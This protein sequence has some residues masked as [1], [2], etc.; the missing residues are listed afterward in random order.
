MIPWWRAEPG[1]VSVRV[2]VQP[3]ARRAGLQGL[4]PG[5]D[6]PRLKL[7]VTEA[8]EDG[9]AN[10][11]VCA[12][13]ARALDMPPSAAEV[14]ARRARH[15]KSWSSS[16]AIPHTLASRLKA[17]GMTARIIDG[18]AVAERLRGQLADRIA[19]LPFRPGLR[20]VRVGDDP[21]SGVYVRNK[22][23]AARAAGFDSVDHPAARRHHASRSAELVE[24]LNT[25]PAVDGILVQ[26]PLPPQIGPQAVIDGDRPGQG[27]GRLPPDQCRPAAD[28]VPALVPCTPLGRHAPARGDGAA[29]LRR[30]ARAWCSAARRSSAGRWPQLLLA[31]DAP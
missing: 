15:G 1:G 18:K 7:A 17:L 26:L 16:P 29:T 27:R 20:V 2:K 19:T 5:V 23:R 4:A 3:R 13:L 24:R 9:R 14:A 21:A 12:A 6:G 28:R 10:K 22:D 25:D 8:P 11:A 31:A 30:R